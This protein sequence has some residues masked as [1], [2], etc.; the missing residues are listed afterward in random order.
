VE[1]CVREI[2]P[3]L[4]ATV[5]QIESELRVAGMFRRVAGV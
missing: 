1:Q 5:R 4:R 2:L 3:E